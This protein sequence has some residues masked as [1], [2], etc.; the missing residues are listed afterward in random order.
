MEIIY[1]HRAFGNLLFCLLATWPFLR[2]LR[3]VGLPKGWVLLLWLN[4]LLPGLGLAAL[5]GLLCHK[6]WP[7]LPKAPPKWVKTKIWGQE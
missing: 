5:T 7:R 6:N 1:H 3:R 4:V 2:I